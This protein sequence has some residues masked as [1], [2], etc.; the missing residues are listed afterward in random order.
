MSHLGGPNNHLFIMQIW[1]SIE[2]T[3]LGA[4][5]TRL[6][7]ELIIEQQVNSFWFFI[8]KQ[9]YLNEQLNVELLK[10][11]NSIIHHTYIIPFILPTVLLS[12][13]LFWFIQLFWSLFL[14]SVVFI[15]YC[16][17]CVYIY[18]C[19]EMLHVDKIRC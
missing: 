13:P 15:I 6:I 9:R 2:C 8:E 16:W 10:I 4:N 1:S 17:Q 12:P 18:T 7:F 11:M 5:I 14:R 3:L 19:L